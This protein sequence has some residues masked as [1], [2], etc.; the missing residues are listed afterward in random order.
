VLQPEGKSLHDVLFFYG[1][2]PP[3]LTPAAHTCCSHLL[4]TPAAIHTSTRHLPHV[5]GAKPSGKER[6]GGPSAAR[7][8]CWKAHW[9]TAPGM[10]GCKVGAGV[11][12]DCPSVSYSSKP[13]RYTSIITQRRIVVAPTTPTPS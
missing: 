6:N 11:G 5:A 7:M 12:K 10:G 1:G 4:F 2:A 3:P 13:E 9:A 8:G